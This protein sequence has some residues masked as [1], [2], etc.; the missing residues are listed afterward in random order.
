[1]SQPTTAADATNPTRYPPVGPSNTAIPAVPAAKTG[2]PTSPLAMYVIWERAPR[3]QPSEAPARRVISVCAVT[4]TGLNGRNKAM[5]PAIAVRLAKKIMT[6]T[7]VMSE[8]EVRSTLRTETD[9]LFS[10]FGLTAPRPAAPERR[11]VELK[12]PSRGVGNGLGRLWLG[13][14]T[15]LTIS[16]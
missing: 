2:S 1:M 14:D 6:R 3:R 12:T 4:G 8:V 13:M 16:V 9:M 11:G 5:R 15:M 7:S 10:E